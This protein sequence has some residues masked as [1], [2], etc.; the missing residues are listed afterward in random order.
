[1]R[2]RLAG[3]RQALQDQQIDLPDEWVVTCPLTIEGAK[4]AAR[5]LL[6]RSP[7]PQA[8]FLSN[9][10]LSL[11]ALQAT[12]ELGLRCPTD[13]ALVGFDDH[14]WAAVSDPPLTVVRQ[15]SR[16]LGR[17]AAQTLCALIGGEPPPAES[18]ILECELVVRESCCMNHA[19]GEARHER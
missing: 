6:L 12:K 11:G 8:L 19:A 2:E 5:R 1:M 14:P 9:N 16:Q 13:I 10:L 4:E 15:P 17:V 3:V 18:V 7:R